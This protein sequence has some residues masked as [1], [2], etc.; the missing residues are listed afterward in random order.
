M[1]V[2]GVGRLSSYHETE[3]T[4]ETSERDICAFVHKQAG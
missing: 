3:T 2:V 1:N 4:I